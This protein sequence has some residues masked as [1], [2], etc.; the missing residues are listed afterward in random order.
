MKKTILSLALALSTLTSAACAE[1]PLAQQYRE[2]LRSG[3]F[4]I[5]YEADYRDHVV[6]KTLAGYGNMRMERSNLKIKGIIPAFA[7]GKKNYPDTLYRDGKYYRFESKKK[8]TVAAASQL[9]DPNID[10]SAGW[11]TIRYNLALPDEF[12]PLYNDAAYRPTSAAMGNF[13]YDGS[14]KKVVAKQEY[15]CDKYTLPLKS[16]AGNTLAELCYY[17]CYDKDKLVYIEKAMLED[18][19]EYILSRVKIKQFSNDVPGELFAM[20]KG[21][22]VYAVGIGDMDDLLNKPAMVEEY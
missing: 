22:K 18:S 13:A 2:W 4:V 5:D 7:Y 10:P 6:S 15:T 16:Q 8:A 12:A 1:Q 14:G 17:Y 21:C 20:P 11:N 3:A 9:A 19:K